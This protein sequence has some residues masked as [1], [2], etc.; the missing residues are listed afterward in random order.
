V[1]DEE[2]ILWRL[3]I[4]IHLIVLLLFLELE[5]VLL[6]NTNDKMLL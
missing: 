5:S 6:K 1:K 4:E 3:T 2:S